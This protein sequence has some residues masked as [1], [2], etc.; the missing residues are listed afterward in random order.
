M[1]RPKKDKDAG[2]ET[3]EEGK[4]FESALKQILSIPKAEIERRETADKER[5]HKSNGKQG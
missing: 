3:N 2:S 5:R 4:A 1:A